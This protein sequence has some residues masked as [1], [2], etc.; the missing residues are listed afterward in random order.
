MASERRFE[1]LEKVSGD[2]LLARKAREGLKL[3]A[4][5]MLKSKLQDNSKSLSPVDEVLV[6]KSYVKQLKEAK[7]A[8]EGDPKHARRLEETA[9]EIEV[10]SA[11]M[12][13]E[14]PAAEIISATEKVLAGLPESR[15]LPLG[16]VMGEVMKAVRN[17]EGGKAVD[18]ARVRS[19]VEATVRK[20]LRL[21]EERN[22]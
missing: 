10:V 14:I 4:L 8:C 6:V 16:P 21:K 5:G 7:A 20:T 15:W 1:L 17:M 18:G 12:P 2:M 22:G 13:K 3:A 19:L 9:A 11:Y